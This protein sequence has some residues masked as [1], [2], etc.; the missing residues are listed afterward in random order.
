[1]VKI[2]VLK[3]VKVVEVVKRR[4]VGTNGGGFIHLPA[5]T[6]KGHLKSCL[7]QHLHLPSA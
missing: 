7:L 2:Q 1:M 5:H 6:I 4:R 3:I